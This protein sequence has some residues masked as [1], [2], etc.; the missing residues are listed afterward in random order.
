M[1]TLKLINEETDRVIK[2]LEK[3]HFANAR[4]AID[5]VQAIDKRR[6][7]AQKELDANKMEANQLAKQIGLLMREG[8]KD[9]AENVKQKVAALKSN[10][11]K[12]LKRQNGASRTRIA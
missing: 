3:K 1:L 11:K 7:E 6:R 10:P 9:E 4:E 12:K 5:N 2:G 8:K